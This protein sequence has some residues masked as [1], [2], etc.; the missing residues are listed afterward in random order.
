[1]AI[2]SKPVIQYASNFHHF[3]VS[4]F[5]FI[6][7]KEKFSN[8]NIVRFVVVQYH[9]QYYHLY[10]LFHRQQRLCC[11]W[12]GQLGKIGGC[13]QM[14]SPSSHSHSLSES[15]LSHRYSCSDLLLSLVTILTISSISLYFFLCA[16]FSEFWNYIN[17]E[18]ILQNTAS[19]LPCDRNPFSNVPEHCL[20]V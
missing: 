14:L 7:S 18:V 9:V 11:H 15:S 20:E 5:T 1:M 16:I 6:K 19:F 10:D 8:F 13:K 17:L 4:I 3:F 2:T 12:W